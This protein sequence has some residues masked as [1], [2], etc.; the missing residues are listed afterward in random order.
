MTEPSSARPDSRLILGVFVAVVLVFHLPLFMGQGVLSRDV[1]RWILPARAVLSEALSHHRLPLWN[2]WQGIGFPILSDPL[3]GPFYPP[4]LLTL[5]GPVVAS[6]ML[7]MLAHV[8]S[9]GAGSYLL[10]RRLNA[11][12]SAALLA[13]LGWSLSGY[14][15][16]E[17]TTGI[18]LLS[19]SYFPWAALAWLGLA[20]AAREG[21]PRFWLRAPIAAVPAAL[22]FLTGEIFLAFIITGFGLVVSLIELS[23][24]RAVLKR[25]AVGALLA[26]VVT[27]LSGAVSVLPAAAIASTTDRSETYDAHLASGL[28][29]LPLR[30]IELF[31]AGSIGRAATL[32][33]AETSRLTGDTILNY[34]LYLGA[35]LVALALCARFRERPARALGALVVALV[36]LALGPRT[37]LYEAFRFVVRPLAYMRSPE[38]YLAGVVPLVAILAAL[39]ATRIAQEGAAPWR[40]L[41][42]FAAFLGVY[43]ALS[44]TL[45][46]GR[47]GAIV[48]ASCLR[49]VVV[50]LLLLAL[51]RLRGRLAPRLPALLV[52][53]VALDLGQHLAVFREYHP[54]AVATHAPPVLAS[55]D[56]RERSPAPLRVFRADSVD[57]ALRRDGPTTSLDLVVDSLR[58]NTSVM[59]GVAILPGYDAAM[60]SVLAQVFASHRRDAL[61]LLAVDY[62]LMAAP[63]PDVARPGLQVVSTP[64]AG[65]HLYRVER[66]LPRAFLAGSVTRLSAR[67][68]NAHLL[69]PDVLDGRTALLSAPSAVAP[70]APADP[71]PCALERYEPGSITARCPA[72][73]AAMAVFVEQYAPGWQASVD[74]QRAPVVPVDRLLVGVPVAAGAHRIRLE[75]RA[76]GLAPGAGLSLLAWGLI[77]LSA[78]QLRASR[79]RGGLAEGAS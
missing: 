55:L 17:W 40:R 12:A 78:W 2:P 7:F 24:E 43:A 79:R 25:F 31:A 73:H 13:A 23:R 65:V 41:V 28:S 20:R 18:R 62:A 34:S 61:R 33:P 22:V 48:A 70:S 53:L 52:A 54:S 36:V 1:I 45:Y 71:T 35:S 42:A 46:G 51:T 21:A 6:A 32:I 67:E 11:S 76:P 72:Q 38:K 69:D 19:S 5:R 30:V 9:G 3:Y 29:L 49:S 57:Q 68:L 64:F 59:S 66:S 47:V 58:E 39:G 16:A 26:S 75:Y 10:A 4:T 37:P 27:G 8:L 63:S 56:A 15:A 60:P 14:I 74:G 50:V 77:A 44:P